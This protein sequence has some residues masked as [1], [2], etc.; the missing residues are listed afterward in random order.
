MV[1]NVST[2]SPPLRHAD[3]KVVPLRHPWRTAAI[4]AVIIALALLTVSVVTNPKFQWPIV[5][6]YMFHER[7]LAGLQTTVLLTVVIMV[8]SSAI[9]TVAALMMISGSRMLSVPAFLFVW[10]FR[11]AP[12]LVQ[13]VI[14]YNLSLVFPRLGL[15]IPGVGTLFSVDTNS[16]MTPMLAA[17]LA[18]ALHEAGYMAEIVRGGLRSVAHGQTEAAACLGMEPGAILRRIV[19]PQAMRMIIPP[20]GNET[21]NLLKTTSLVSVIAVGDILYA[22]QSIYARTFETIPL[23]LV[24]T[25]WYLTVVSVMSVGQFYLERYFSREEHGHAPSALWLVLRHLSR[26]R[27]GVAT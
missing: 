8:L 17:I 6:Q 27:R 4:V 16:I 20:T 9:G 2:H 13:L 21:I 22:A 24:V 25:F 19:L 7:I 18:L 5:A 26:F 11:G 23:L 12:A 3:F 1:S 15:W 14:W 10:L